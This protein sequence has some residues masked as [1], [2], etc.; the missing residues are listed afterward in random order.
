MRKYVLSLCLLL[1]S[2]A[3]K[4]QT[5]DQLWGKVQT[6]HNNDLPQTALSVVEQIKQKALHESNDAQLLRAMLMQRIYHADVAP[7]S[8]NVCIERIE[9]ML[10]KET[11]AV[12]KALWHSALAQCYNGCHTY[13]Y[14]R[15]SIHDD[16]RNKA[17]TH[18]EASLENMEELVKARVNDYFPL[19]EQGEGSTVFNNDLLHVLFN[20]YADS[21]LLSTEERRTWLERLGKFYASV[22]NKDAALIYYTELVSHSYN[23][24]RI[25]TKVECDSHYLALAKLANDSKGVKTNVRTYIALSELSQLYDDKAPYA[26]H[27]DSVLMHWVKKGIETYGK[28]REANTLRNWV[29]AQTQPSAILSNLQQ[30]YYPAVADTLL[31]RARNV[32][33]AS[34]VL[35]RI[36]GKEVDVD[37]IT[38]KELHQLIKK[39]GKTSVHFK[40]TLTAAPNYAWQNL[41]LNITLPSM[42]GIYAV[43]LMADGKTLTTQTLSVT[44]LSVIKF[45]T[46]QSLNRITVIDSRTGHTVP[47][48]KIT[49]YAPHRDGT[50]RQVKVYTANEQ[51][52]VNIKGDRSER[53]RYSVS[54]DNDAASPCF[55]L[56]NIRG[57]TTN[58]EDARTEVEVFTDRGIYRPGQTVQF[59]AIAHTHFG[60]NYETANHLA[61]RAEL[62]NVN[63]RLLDSLDVRT[64]EWGNLHGAFTLPSTCLTGYFRII[65]KNNNLYSRKAFKVEEYKRPTFT[66]TTEPLN[67][68]YMLGDTVR[69][70]GKASTYTGVAVAN[71]RVQYAVSRSVWGLY[72]NDNAESQTGETTTDDKGAFVLPVALTKREDEGEPLRYNRYYFTVSYTVTAEN[73]ETAQG[74]TT[75]SVATKRT[76]LQTDLADVVYRRNGSALSPFN[77]RL[78]NAEGNNVTVNGQYSIVQNNKVVRTNTFCTNEPLAFAPLLSLPSG[79]YVLRATT[80]ADTL[81][82]TFTLVSENDSTPVVPNGE[83]FSHYDMSA[84]GDTA[85]VVFGSACRNAIVF[86]DIVANNKV[87]ESK[88]INVSNVLQHLCFAYNASYGTG[89]T[90][91]LAMVRNGKL[92]KCEVS[93]KKPEPDKRLL[94]HWTSF[95]SRLTPGAEEQWRLQVTHPDGSPAK[96]QLMACIYDNSLDA[97]TS[98]RWNNFNINFYRPLTPVSLTYSAQASPLHLS[99]AFDI[100]YLTT[101]QT[102]LTCWQPQLFSAYNG[103]AYLESA[104]ALSFGPRRMRA[105]ALTDM[106]SSVSENK[107]MLKGTGFDK[108]AKVSAPIAAM[109]TG[110]KGTNTSVRTN[111][112]ETAYF[113]PAL[114]TDSTGETTISFTLPRS[115]T[116]WNFTAMAHDGA[117]NY[118][119]IDTTAIA[120]KDFMVEPALPR[121]L[122][123]NDSTNLPVKVTNLSANSVQ[124]VLTLELVDALTEVTHYKGEQTIVVPA[125]QSQVF[126]FPYTTKGNDGVL[127][128]RT[129]AQCATFS[130]GEE[131]YLPILNSDVEVVRSIPFSMTEKNKTL[132]IDTLFYTDKAQHRALSVEI[133]SNPTWY[134]VSALPAL[135]NTEGC[136]SANECAERLYALMLGQYIVEKQPEIATLA[137]ET[138]EAKALMA[139]QAEGLTDAT[140]WLQQGNAQNARAKAFQQMFNAEMNA[141]LL[142]TAKEKLQALQQQDG[143]FSWFPGMSGNVR[144]TTNIALLLARIEQL[145]GNK[146]AHSL[147]TAAFSYLQLRIAEDVERMKREEQRNR[148]KMHPD[149]WQIAYLYLR[150]LMDVKPDAAANYLID[151]AILRSKDM[152]MLGKARM[153]VVLA[154]CKKAEAKLMVRSLIEHT[155]A[156][157]EMGRY[158]DT[159]R[160]ENTFHS[161]RIPTQCATIEALQLV[162]EE[163]AT[164]EQMLLWLMQSKRTQMWETSQSTTDAVYTLLLADTLTT[165]VLP[166][167]KQQTVF[168]SLYNKERLIDA[169][170]RSEAKLP[171]TVGYFNKTYTNSEEVAATT[172]KLRKNGD[173]LA[174]GS[175][176]ASF[177]VPATEVKSDGNELRQNRTFEIKRNGAWTAL[178]KDDSVRV[179]DRLRQVYCIIAKRDFDFVCVSSSRAACCEPA[180]PLSGYYCSDNLWAYRAVHDAY[181]QL[182]IEKLSKGTHYLTEEFTIDRTGQFTT[183]ISKVESVYNPEYSA[184]CEENV[185]NVVR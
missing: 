123:M 88:R 89:A 132:H 152:D 85:W 109:N 74:N 141:A 64:D 17:K 147:L 3:A 115:M 66:A 129:V 128:C 25:N 18:F 12:E 144:T 173:G 4:A 122:R 179:G 90:L 75:V 142:Y 52:I 131:H 43:Q 182:F 79:Q 91:F 30:C 8:A 86:Y 81:T 15:A 41:S 101:P 149:E 174:W 54:T 127:I 83:W 26:V 67:K 55:Y 140:P 106:S 13:I 125:G 5:Y 162:G 153:A 137:H 32:K 53:L 34:V 117:M 84:K 50:Y 71:A 40:G 61:L 76:V 112:A 146:E 102:A 33:Q 135:F 159:P 9:K 56:S 58:G 57:Y 78:L 39:N 45:A 172:I 99:G 113:H 175:V 176:R 139:L 23:N 126:T 20:A 118:G 42:P 104:D 72:N 80:E 178:A 161:Y 158:F 116:Q 21:G 14:N 154:Q 164:I 177:M 19:F 46:P 68:G 70:I 105:F 165:A 156:T 100:K 10:N 163:H 136:V 69:V 160:A 29:L 148:T 171:L 47:H 184:I 185:I 124:A 107:V 28:N 138:D 16:T 65:V 169:N 180:Q 60:D 157:P 168:Y 167:N 49:A 97:F 183:G 59:T 51:G 6:A 63:D 170:A 7:D 31:I 96:A 77:I 62:R 94:L 37:N 36:A 120:R 121:F 1:L 143:S 181:T 155:V 95:R 98:N 111:F 87:M 130:D 35:T 38:D 108:Q 166:V 103:M 92:H 93:I 11:R 44:S 151:R 133:A 82:K 2:I 150:A 114:L 145:T 48:A 73:G 27:N 119:R 24:K 110:A 22:G 134:A